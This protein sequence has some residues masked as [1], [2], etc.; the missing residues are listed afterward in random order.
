MAA[1]NKNLVAVHPN[2]QEDQ[3]QL[4]VDIDREKAGALSLNLADINAAFST[5][6]GSSYADD[7]L[8]KG[9]IKKVYMQGDTPFRTAPG[10]ME[11]RFS[12]N[13]KGEM[14][15]F[16]SFASAYWERAPACLERYNDIPS[17]E[18]LGQSAPDVSSGT[19]I[20]EMEKLV[21]RLPQGI[22]YEWTGLSCQERLSG[23][24]APALFA[25]SI[26]VVFLY[27]AALYESWSVPLVA[28]L[29]VPFDVLGAPGAASMR[30]LSNDV[31]F[32]AGLP[33]IIGLSAK[34]AIL[35]VEFVKELYGKGGDLTEATIEASRMRLRP[36]L[37]TLLIS[38]FGILPPAISTDAGTDG[39]N[40]ISTGVTG[41]A[42]VATA[43]GIFY[44][45]VF[46]V[47]VTSVFSF[48]WKWK[49]SRRRR[50]VNTVKTI[51]GDS[52]RQCQQ[53]IW[54]PRWRCCY[55]AARWPRTTSVQRPWWW[56]SGPTIPC[57]R[58][59]FSPRPPIS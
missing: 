47:V 30:M 6:W 40:A 9:C 55:P 48:C 23:S 56:R 54:R 37:M 34:N 19:A 49:K 32:Q 22:G 57:P 21:S 36:T 26:L 20:S 58:A 35:I 42:F 2:G 51:P 53:S 15:P 41:G 8:D 38:L 18:I 24:Q 52:H 31:Y 5:V 10:D 27:P 11:E 3:S 33:T 59:Q 12:C 14:V 16:S 13:S 44:I 29:V 25:P 7:F 4:R 39:Q 50:T 45:S 28:I 46:F 1:Q 17:V 43:L